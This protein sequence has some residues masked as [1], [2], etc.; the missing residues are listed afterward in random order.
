MFEINVWLGFTVGLAVGAG[1]TAWLGRS[2]RLTI[3]QLATEMANRA[4]TERIKDLEALNERMKE[5]FAA[6]S[7]E[8]LAKNSEQLATVAGRT[9]KYQ[10]QLGEQ[11]LEGKKELIDRT[12][13]QIGQELTKVQQMVGGMEK[14]RE[15]KFGELSSQL[16]LT[17]EA[18]GRLQETTQN[19]Q[20]ALANSRVRGQW[21][22]RMAEDVLRMSGLVEGINY[23]KQQCSGT[24]SRPDFTFYLP[25]DLKINMDVKF[26]LDNYLNFIRTEEAAARESYKQQFLKDARRRI[27][28][29]TGRDYINPEDRTVDYVLVFIPNEQIYG[30]INELDGTLLDDALK[31]RVVLCSPLTLYAFLA[32]IRQAVENYNLEQTT[33]RVLALLGGFYKQW[34]NYCA[35][36]ERMGR[37]LNDAQK[38]YA[39][40]TATRRNQLEKPLQALEELRRQ[41][42]MPVEELEVAAADFSET[43]SPVREEP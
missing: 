12:L 42:N 18:T 40:L 23:R 3:A 4:Q 16:K 15:Q 26:P 34:E 21:G 30:L 1:L 17:A 29:V 9:L 24:G 7:Y 27:K 13:A 8:A 35:A 37:R 43:E 22:E 39:N 25:K 31:N 14:D 20:G 10:T 36:M 41:N 28:E 32:V 6:L 33:S 2:R 5:S 11:N 38:E 19:L